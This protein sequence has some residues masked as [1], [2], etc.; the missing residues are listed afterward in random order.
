M[1]KET[2]LV[3]RIL[4]AYRNAGAYAVKIHGDQSQP[5][6]VDVH[7]CYKG[8]FIALEVKREHGLDATPAQKEVIRQVQRAWGYTAVAH[9][10]R[11]ALD[12][13]DT[14]DRDILKS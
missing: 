14:I 5:R 6:D 3:E 2:P 11:E 13:L 4:D 9:D 8:R 10:L 1:P 12:V 7:A